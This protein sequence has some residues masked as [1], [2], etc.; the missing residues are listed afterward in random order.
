MLNTKIFEDQITNNCHLL[1]DCKTR[2][3]T[4]TET[5]QA[6]MKRDKQKRNETR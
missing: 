4:E 2:N 3:E 5:K 6:E 1:V